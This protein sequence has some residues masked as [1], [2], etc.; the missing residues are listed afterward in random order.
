MYWFFLIETYSIFRQQNAEAESRKRWPVFVFF[1]FLIET[2]CT[3]RQRSAE[4]DTGR[5]TK[6]RSLA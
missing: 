6:P 4:A 5:K 1:F 2:Y 3:S